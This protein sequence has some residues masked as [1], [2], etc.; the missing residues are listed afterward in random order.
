MT[1]DPAQFFYTEAQFLNF[2]D[3]EISSLHTSTTFQSSI[4]ARYPKRRDFPRSEYTQALPE[5][6]LV[7]LDQ[8]LPVVLPEVPTHGLVATTHDAY[9]WVA[10]QGY[11]SSLLLPKRFELRQQIVGV[12]VK[13]V[14]LEGRPAAHRRADSAGSVL[15]SG[16]VGPKWRRRGIGGQMS[17]P[18]SPRILPQGLTTTAT[19]NSMGS[20]TDRGPRAWHR[21]RLVVIFTV[22]E[23]SADPDH[24]QS[25]YALHVYGTRTESDCLENTLM[26]AM[27]DEQVI[28]L[29]FC[30]SSV[31]VDTRWDSAGRLFCL[32]SGLQGELDVLYLDTQLSL[33]RSGPTSAV[34]PRII[35]PVLDYLQSQH[36]AGWVSFAFYTD[37]S[38]SLCAIGDTD[39][40]LYLA[41]VTH[42]SVDGFPGSP[43]TKLDWQMTKIRLFNLVTSL[44]FFQDPPSQN[45]A[46]ST[47]KPRIQT[48][49]QLL[50][51]CANEAALVIPDVASGTLASPRVLP[52]SHLYDS[53][54]TAIAFDVNYDGQLELVTGSYGQMLLIYGKGS[55]DQE[56]KV[57]WK[58]QFPFP[59]YAIYLHDVN[60]DGVEELV[61]V[62]MRGV[63]ILQPNLAYLRAV[64]LDKLARTRPSDD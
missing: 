13:E 44:R 52:E 49:W 36:A 43:T 40:N 11:W 12:C 17:A 61:V 8:V 53:V 28:P 19:S 54:T 20:G 10:N 50:V 14:T 37:S 5:S 16:E 45:S 58:H 33:T 9:A 64:I 42:N 34:K 3:K 22:M 38:H 2:Q 47:D 51:T 23:L 32:V 15:S 1:V 7:K 6:K 57:R 63:H 30:P 4:P 35:Q 21:K 48:P 29:T 46:Q 26:A 41:H 56:Y 18:G 55:D 25:T 27:A 60:L 39:E 62:T 24:P 59:I 31:V